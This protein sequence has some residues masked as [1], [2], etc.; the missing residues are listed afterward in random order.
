[1]PKYIDRV[2]ALVPEVANKPGIFTVLDT[3]LMVDSTSLISLGA[4]NTGSEEAAKYRY[5]MISMNGAWA[6][7]SN[8]TRFKLNIARLQVDRNMIF[9]SSIHSPMEFVLFSDTDLVG[10]NLAAYLK[11]LKMSRLYGPKILEILKQ[12]GYQVREFR[13]EQ[14]TLP[15]TKSNPVG[16][17]YPATGSKSSTKAGITTSI[18]KALTKTAI[19]AQSPTTIETSLPKSRTITQDAT[20]VFPSKESEIPK[21]S[22]AKSTENSQFDSFKD[23]KNYF[24]FD[25]DCQDIS[26][27]DCDGAKYI[28][29]NH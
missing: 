28:L 18:L 5:Q 17:N 11:Q 23:L 7:M 27:V 20:Q 6:P 10:L 12:I 16:K 26:D 19:Q 21:L 13:V 24:V 8:N 2:P 14:E 25:M 9:F 15:A 22:D 3:L 29:N 1:M 4:D